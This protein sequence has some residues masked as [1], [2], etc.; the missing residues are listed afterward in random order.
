MRGLG[1]RS[2]LGRSDGSPVG[3]SAAVDRPCAVVAGARAAQADPGR[4]R[5]SGVASCASRSALW[6]SPSGRAGS[7]RMTWLKPTIEAS[8][9]LSSCSTSDTLRVPV[10]SRRGRHV[11]LSHAAILARVSSALTD[12][13]RLLQATAREFAQRE[14]APGAIERDEA[15]RYDRS[16]FA[17]M[18]ALGL[19]AA[20][21]PTAVGGAGFSYLGWT[22]VMEELG[23]RGHGDGGVAVG[24]HPVA[25]PGRDLGHGR[26]AGALAAG[27]AGGRGAGGVRADRA[28]RRVRCGARS[29]RGPSGSGRPMRRRRTG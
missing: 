17:A 9:L 8:E 2:G 25:V 6:R 10:A 14:V 13:E 27:D 7:R 16:L 12:E 28:A 20:P 19:T 18:G 1:V 11:R 5:G 24:P 4:V 15:E 29:G 23:R 22:L 21:F 3:A 26:A